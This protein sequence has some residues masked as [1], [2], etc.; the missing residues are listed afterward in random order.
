MALTGLRLPC[1][2]ANQSTCDGLRPER[3]SGAKKRNGA[4]RVRGWAGM[5]LGSSVDRRRSLRPC[6]HGH[7][8]GIRQREDGDTDRCAATRSPATLVR[9][10]VKE[11]ES[12]V[13]PGRCSRP[14]AKRRHRRQRKRPDDPVL[15][16]LAPAARERRLVGRA[17]ESAAVG[18]GA[19]QHNVV[20][21]DDM[22]RRPSRIAP[23]EPIDMATAQVVRA[24]LG[25]A[26]REKAR[27]ELS[28]L[29]ALIVAGLLAG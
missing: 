16:R 29:C 3:S 1:F 6:R 4:H 9:N 10:P 20:P 27:R 28:P 22:T 26:C 14:C 23:H 18:A 15:A 12:H 8:I 13:L 25:N 11:D 2:R 24:S 17:T 5:A 21:C 19:V 7:N